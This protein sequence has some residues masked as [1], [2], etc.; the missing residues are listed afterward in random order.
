MRRRPVTRPKSRPALTHAITLQPGEVLIDVANECGVAGHQC[1]PGC[2]RMA[3][4]AQQQIVA[5]EDGALPI[6]GWDGSGR[7]D[8][9]GQV[10]RARSGWRQTALRR[11]PRGPARVR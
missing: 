7:D 4:V 2:A 11:R 5:S 3:F 6:R 9:A 10:A 1:F 8:H